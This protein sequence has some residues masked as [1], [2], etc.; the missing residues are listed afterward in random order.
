MKKKMR[1]LFAGLGLTLGLLLLFTACGK[2]E[3]ASESGIDKIKS[4]KKLVVATAS[5][6]APYEFFDLNG[7]PKKIVGVDMEFAQ[8]VADDLGVDLEV[9]DM[10]F[11]AILGSVTQNQV[12]FAIA[13]MTATD[14]R[15]KSVD[16]TDPYIINKNVVIVLKGNESKYASE[17]S[18]AD[19]K[20]AVQK[21]T[22]QET[23]AQE[24]LKPKQLVSLDKLPD[25]FLNLTTGQVD[26]VVVEKTVAMQYVL[27]DD[28]IAYADVEIPG[29]VYTSIAV[30]KG[31]EDLVKRLNKLIKEN[32]DNGN[33]DK[34]LEEYSIIAQKSATAE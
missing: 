22:T 11:S 18:F 7:D 34:W 21:A 10:T 9:K 16:F 25:A 26:G 28:R 20:L 23:I 5:G 24:D 8:V 33:F 14:E 30:P 19:A 32:Q 27:T 3:E 17:D 2:N 15:K 13:G 4:A 29:E 1:K 6:Y 31:N 12:D